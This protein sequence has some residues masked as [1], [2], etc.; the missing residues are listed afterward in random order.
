MEKN[1][2]YKVMAIVALL[3]GIVGLSIGFAAFSK[4][5]NI[6]TA[7]VNTTART[8]VF[9]SAIHYDT[10]ATPTS[11]ALT[12][13]TVQNVGT[14]TTDTWSNIAFT[15]DANENNAS[16]T[17]T[18]TVVND[19]SEY[20]AYLQTITTSDG[21]IECTPATGT[22]ATQVAT[23]CSKMKVTVTIAGQSNNA[24]AEVTSSSDIDTTITN[25]VVLPKSGN[26]TVTVKFDYDNDAV[27]H[28]GQ[29]TVTLPA[30]SFGYTSTIIGD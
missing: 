14:L 17:L 26:K 8:N 7:T 20:D 2:G 3:V 11:S 27:I 19:S 10:T 28:D 12:N 30:I 23:A 25:A 18:A 5:L 16:A 15:I 6:G 21:V 24:T 4:T 13:V 9:E 29:F 22:D 1:N